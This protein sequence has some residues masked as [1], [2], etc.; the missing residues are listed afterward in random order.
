M[1]DTPR[2]YAAPPGERSGRDSES[3]RHP[4]PHQP[5]WTLV[6][7]RVCPPDGAEMAPPRPLLHPRRRD[8]C[9]QRV[10]SKKKISLLYAI[11]LKMQAFHAPILS[12]RA[13][14]PP[15]AGRPTGAARTS[16]GPAAGT[17][18]VAVFGPGWCGRPAAP[19]HGHTQRLHRQLRLP[20]AR[21]P[22]PSPRT[23]HSGVHA[24][25]MVG[26][27]GAP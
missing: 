12:P 9:G 16:R 19:W 14:P 22:R 1:G 3:S 11:M 23:R 24:Y 27:R 6:G 17:A 7:Q 13:G 25:V 26:A 18:L 8:L 4:H 20:K 15:L 5:P 10:A 21:L 2:T